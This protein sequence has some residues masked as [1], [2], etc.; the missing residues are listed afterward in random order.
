VLGISFYFAYGPAAA[1]K[2]FAGFLVA[3]HL[4]LAWVF[5]AAVVAALKSFLGRR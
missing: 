4:G 5:R 3:C 1:L 2:M